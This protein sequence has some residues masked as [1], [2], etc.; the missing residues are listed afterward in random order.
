MSKE[1]YGKDKEGKKMYRKWTPDHKFAITME[2][3]TERKSVADLCR[4][5]R[6]PPQLFSGW[7][8][9]FIENGKNVFEKQ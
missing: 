9:E 2:Y 5:H 7:R 3:F 6:L 8:D 1:R 4:K